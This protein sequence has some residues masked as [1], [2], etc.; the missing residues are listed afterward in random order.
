[1]PVSRVLAF[2]AFLGDWHAGASRI[3]QR[4]LTFKAQKTELAS[5]AQE[6]ALDYCLPGFSHAGDAR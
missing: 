2:V 1:M 4:V 5:A 6:I 3:A